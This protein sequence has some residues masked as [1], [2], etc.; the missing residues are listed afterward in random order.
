M[1]EVIKVKWIK[2]YN[3]LYGEHYVANTKISNCEILI[4]NRHKTLNMWTMATISPSGRFL[5]YDWAGTL[6]DIKDRVLE[7]ANSRGY[8][9]IRYENE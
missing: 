1:T 8:I 9:N 7:W 4:L 2:S 5:P 3:P 6:Q